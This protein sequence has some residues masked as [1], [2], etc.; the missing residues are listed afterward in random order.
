MLLKQFVRC[1]L[2]K[3]Q[4]IYKQHGLVLVL[5]RLWAAMAV[6]V[7]DSRLLAPRWLLPYALVQLL[8]ELMRASLFH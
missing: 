1:S 2:I 7:A 3:T 5:A 6:Q 8:N 4:N